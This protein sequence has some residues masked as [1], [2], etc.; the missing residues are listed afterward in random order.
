[1]RL[2]SVRPRSATGALRHAAR[3][4]RP[5]PPEK[6]T[7]PLAQEIAGLLSLM[8]VA[9]LLLTLCAVFGWAN[10]KFLPLSRSVGLLV[11]SVATSAVLLGLNALFPKHRLFALLTDTLRQIDFIAIIPSQ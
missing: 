10:Y 11:M 2:R 6:S 5:A 7:V 1:M 3:E 8:D 9:A 4:G